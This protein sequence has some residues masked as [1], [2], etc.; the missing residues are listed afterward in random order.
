MIGFISKRALKIFLITYFVNLAEDIVLLIYY[1]VPI[2][3]NE[4]IAVGVFSLAL[5]LI[6]D[7]FILV[8]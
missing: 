4:F 8:D 5:A 6:I 2:G 1:S 7:K 3:R